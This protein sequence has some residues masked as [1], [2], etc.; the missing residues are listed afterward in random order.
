MESMDIAEIRQRLREEWARDAGLASSRKLSK[1]QRRAR[2][3]K[4]G[5]ASGKARALRKKAAR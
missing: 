2:A 3:S 4:A 5:K 1:Q